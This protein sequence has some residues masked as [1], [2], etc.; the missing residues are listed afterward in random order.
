MANQRDPPRPPAPPGDGGYRSRRGA[1]GF[2][3]AL[4]SLVWPEEGASRPQ[5]EPTAPGP[6][7]QR[8]SGMPRRVTPRQGLPPAPPVAAE[9]H[10]WRRP[11]GSSGR[12]KKQLAQAKQAW[13]L[14]RV[15][16]LVATDGHLQK[17]AGLIQERYGLTHEEAEQQVRR[18][19]G[20]SDQAGR[21]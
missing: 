8:L 7:P 11:A 3:G 20:A 9:A 5:G 19:L 15:D 16:E 21:M 6:E 12:W 13:P 2:L 17:L 1:A 18:F 4:K 10:P 14:L